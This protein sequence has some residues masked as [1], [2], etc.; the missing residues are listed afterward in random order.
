MNKAKLMD[1]IAKATKVPADQ[2]KAV[3]DKLA[4][5]ATQEIIENSTF[6]LRG[7]GSFAVY[8]TPRYH[9]GKKWVEAQ[10]ELRFRPAKAIRDALEL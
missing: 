6:T 10:N 7:F 1:R 9:D 4:E 3:V 2:V 8:N 5:V